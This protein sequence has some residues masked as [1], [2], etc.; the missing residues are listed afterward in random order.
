MTKIIKYRNESKINHE[1]ITR[2]GEILY[3]DEEVED[4]RLRVS[5]KNGCSIDF[6][7]HKE[8]DDLESIFGREN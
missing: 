3:C 1:L 7:R 8:D 2:I 4:I 6:E 5:L